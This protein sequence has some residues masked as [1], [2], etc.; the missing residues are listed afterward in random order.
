MWVYAAIVFSAFAL[1]ALVYRY[2][3]YDKEPWPLLLLVFFA[4]M[5]SGWAAGRLEDA[6]LL[7][8]GQ[9]GESVA[10]QA[11]LASLT[12]ESLKLLVVLAVAFLFR[13]EFNDPLDGLI[14]GAFAGL[15]A[16]VEESWFYVALS[17]DLPF[18]LV[19]TEIIRL[20]LHVFLGGLA[21]LGVGLVRFRIPYWPAI[22]L[23]ALA[24]DLLIHF[25]WDSL[26]GIPA[27]SGEAMLV[28]RIIAIG[29]ML[30]GLGVFGLSV[31]WGSRWSRAVFA[32]R[33]SKRL[34]GWPFSLIFGS[35]PD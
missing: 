16:A 6:A 32:P 2:D 7:Y 35:K 11:A 18:A 17:D 22:F 23:G 13:R 29:L 26:C 3:L 33:S 5:L 21:G 10:V 31:F 28:Q 30:A 1:A 8:L 14:Y 12:E 20:I 19:G 9:R 24:A 34:W 25:A 4:G 15:G 27:M